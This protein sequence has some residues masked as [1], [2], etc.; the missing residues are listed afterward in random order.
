MQSIVVI[1]LSSDNHANGTAIIIS[2]EYLCAAPQ[3]TVLLALS[4]KAIL[5]WGAILH[6]MLVYFFRRGLGGTAA[7]LRSTAVGSC[8]TRG[9]EAACAVGHSSSHL[10]VNYAAR[11]ERAPELQVA[12]AF[13]ASTVVKAG[14]APKDT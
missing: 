14:A 12:G 10:A 13:E 9:S 2:S 8:G 6:L 4:H 3:V 1:M 11:P 5:S 7:S